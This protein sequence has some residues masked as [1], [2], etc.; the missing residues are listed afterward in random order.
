VQGLPPGE[1]LGIPAG[2]GGTISDTGTPDLSNPPH[3]PPE[4][5]EMRKGMPTAA[6]LLPMEPVVARVITLPVNRLAQREAAA[7][8]MPAAPVATAPDGTVL[9]D[10]YTIGSGDEKPLMG[11][12][13]G[14]LQGPRH[15]GLRRYSGMDSET[16][17]DADPDEEEQGA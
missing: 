8:H 2:P 7:E 5:D 14:L 11:K 15:M 13:G 16:P 3:R 4:S 10:P 17:M 9:L 1:P 12:E 6:H